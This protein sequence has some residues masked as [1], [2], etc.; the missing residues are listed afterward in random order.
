MNKRIVTTALPLAGLLLVSACGRAPANLEWQAPAMGTTYT[1]KVVSAPAGITR[2]ALQSEVAKILERID[3]IFSTYRA[4]SEISRFNAAFSTDWLGVSQ[5]MIAVVE[6]AQTTSRLTG[7]AF[8]ITLA[9]LVSLWGFGPEL[10]DERVPGAAE[11]ALLR[12][13]MG[14]QK[15]HY[16]LRPP[17][18]RKQSEAIQ[19]DLNAL[20]AGYAADRVAARLEQ[21]GIRNYMVDM[22][23]ELRLKGHNARGDPWAIAIE[24]PLPERQ[25][26]KWVLALTDCALSTS[27]N[28]RNFFEVDG[29]RYPHVLDGRSGRPTRHDLASVTVIA[30]SAMHADA[31]ATALLILGPEAGY[32][33]AERENVA[34]LFI[35]R[36]DGDF[37]ETTSPAFRTYLPH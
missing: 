12:S 15:L 8:D 27:G 25:G 1:V 34:A 9:P 18:L 21:A 13:R 19:I 7:G 35:S 20:V 28:Y 16:R 10:G 30:Q 26:V 37:E 14:Y 23:G 2:G 17:A 33:L 3:R 31:W 36:K 6:A 29:V 4:D 5:S 24:N 32:A 22:G 11:I